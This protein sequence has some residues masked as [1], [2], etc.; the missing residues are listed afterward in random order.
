[1]WII[2]NNELDNFKS[3]AWKKLQAEKTEVCDN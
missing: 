3:N 2:F 1:M